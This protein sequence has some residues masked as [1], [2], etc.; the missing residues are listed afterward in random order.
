M[1]YAWIVL[2]AALLAGCPKADTSH[3]EVEQTLTDRE[4][5]LNRRDLALYLS[6]VSRDYGKDVTGYTDAATIATFAT[7]EKRAT[8]LFGMLEQIRYTSSERSLYD[9]TDGRVRVI[10]RYVMELYPRQATATTAAPVTAERR[11]FKSLSG[12]E[13]LWLVREADGRWR[14]V[15]GL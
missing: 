6:A 2:T 4:N 10:Q 5:G 3:S 15:A 9:E 14:I 1:R 7:L 8:R 12:Q 11:N 13:Q